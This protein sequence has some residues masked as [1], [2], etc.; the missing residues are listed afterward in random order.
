VRELFID[1]LQVS[2]PNHDFSKVINPGSVQIPGA[3]AI[4]ASRSSR[5]QCHKSALQKR[6]HQRELNRLRDSADLSGE[7]SLPFAWKRFSGEIG[8]RE[9]LGLFRL[10][11]G[12]KLD[13]SAIPIE[14][15]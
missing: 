14:F 8:G 4:S 11:L 7:R 13:S 9:S 2:H 5:Q 6:K 3:L 1:E 10:L 12:G 15:M